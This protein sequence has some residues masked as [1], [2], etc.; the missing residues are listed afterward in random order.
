[1]NKAIFL[2]RDGVINKKGKE[3]YIWK[4][5][6]F[7]FNQGVIEALKVFKS[8]GYLLIVITNQGGI[9]KKVF[10][11]DQLSLLHNYMEKELDLNNA[12]LTH[13]YYCPHHSDNEL[14]ECR[15]PGSLLF[16]KAIKDY[17]IDPNLSYM[18]GDSE[19]DMIASSRAGIKGINIPT[20]CNMMT[21]FEVYNF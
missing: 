12:G 8:R 10:T 7:E 14:C 4:V 18:I 1:M 19:V 16:E 11:E 15:K 6:D 21:L 20:N 9:S 2:D 5:E 13:I 3:Y 17:N